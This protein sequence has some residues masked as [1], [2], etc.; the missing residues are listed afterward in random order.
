MYSRMYVSVSTHT[1]PRADPKTTIVSG[2][3]RLGRVSAIDRSPYS[4]NG[5]E[6]IE[7]RITD[8]QKQV[9]RLAISPDKNFVAAAGSNTVR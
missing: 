5:Y 3:G 9:N 2:S 6:H 1:G 8:I 4:L 7:E